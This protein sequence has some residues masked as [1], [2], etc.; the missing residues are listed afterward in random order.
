MNAFARIF[1]IAVFC[2]NFLN[3][4]DGKEINSVHLD[5][6][7]AQIFSNPNHVKEE[8]NSLKA[9]TLDIP[10]SLNFQKFNLI[11][12]YYGVFGQF[13][14]AYHY[15]FKAISYTPV[16]SVKRADAL[17]KLAIVYRNQQKN[18]RA[19][20][21]LSAALRLSKR[22][23]D[24]HSTAMIYC[25][26]AGNYHALFQDE[27]VVKYLVLS[28][29]ILD[30][31]PNEKYSD[32]S[33]VRNNLARTYMNNANID[34]AIPL[35]EKSMEQY[36]N[37][38]DLL[39]F[40]LCLFD[41]A[42]CLLAKKKYVKADKIIKLAILG[43]KDFEPK[44]ALVQGYCLYGKLYQAVGKEK[45]ADTYFSK[46]L[47][48]ISYAESKNVLVI[49]SNNLV[50][51]NKQKKYHEAIALAKPYEIEIPEANWEDRIS[52][53][54]E[55]TSA[56]LG[57]GR[58]DESIISFQ[59]YI[60]IKEAFSKVKSNYRVSELQN[61][62]QKLNE[63]KDAKVSEAVSWALVNKLKYQL[64]FNLFLVGCL[65]FLGFIIYSR[66]RIEKQ[67]KSLFFEKIR[68]EK[69]ERMLSQFE[70][71]SQKIINQN[72]L[73]T[74]ENQK[75]EI[76]ELDYS[77]NVLNQKL[78]EVFNLLKD[79]KNISIQELENKLIA[80]R[81][82]KNYWEKFYEKFERLN[83]D[84]INKI[85]SQN[86]QLSHSDL[87]FIALVKLNLSPKEIASVFAISFEK[88][89]ARKMELSEKLKL[90]QTTSL[91]EYVQSIV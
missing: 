27:L 13:D 63:E 40:N 71:E 21:V 67:K 39:N 48:N 31:L 77:S 58:V 62:Y 64:F 47:Q 12:V 8:L 25:E 2:L 60:K 75:N 28:L 57:L 89:V 36:K 5:S 82:V 73:S 19:L 4:I 17:R 54:L 9:S 74:I 51:L 52:F 16:M 26:M 76:L 86:K 33:I 87:Q 46:A 34:F 56:Y 81:P 59:T 6:L 29:D 30:K 88:V 22:F 11:G 66:Y 53:Q 72:S 50:I 15:F 55:L 44:R 41:Y 69:A 7:F 42:E 80:L 78:D 84:F 18:K 35:I 68:A 70:L 32:L 37:N 38:H 49:V 45:L 10:D 20:Q 85:S 24:K 79:D 61:A 23:G 43:S 1:L 65:L 91:D 3:S 90:N 83:A 14:S